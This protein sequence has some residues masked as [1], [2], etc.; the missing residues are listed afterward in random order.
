MK[1]RK[2]L[3]CLIVAISATLQ[4]QDGLPVYHDYFADNL[5]LLH[6]SMA[7]A[8]SYGKLRMTARQQWFDQTEAPNIQ[9]ASYHNRVGQNSGLGAIVLTMQM[10]ITLKLE[11]I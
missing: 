7:G 11:D 1:L 3:F 4:A 8:S 2:T 9:T 5:Y 6:P 10:V